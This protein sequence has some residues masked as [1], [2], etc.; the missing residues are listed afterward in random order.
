MCQCQ[1]PVPMNICGTGAHKAQ[2]F[3]IWFR[4]LCSRLAGSFVPLQIVHP[5]R[6]THTLTHTLWRRQAQDVHLAIFRFNAIRNWSD[7]SRVCLFINAHGKWILLSTAHSPSLMYGIWK[8]A[9]VIFIGC[10]GV[11]GGSK[12]CTA[13]AKCPDSDHTWALESTKTRG[14]W[15][16]THIWNVRYTLAS[17]AIAP[18]PR[19]FVHDDEGGMIYWFFVWNMK[20]CAEIFERVQCNA[21]M[22]G[23]EAGVCSSS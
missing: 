14:F 12:D 19:R 8:Y 23:E 2:L 9:F 4:V 17:N 16:P 5:S 18:S 13:L 15:R 3:C 7:S 21:R 1:C 10:N 22:A 20:Q 6:H 11:D